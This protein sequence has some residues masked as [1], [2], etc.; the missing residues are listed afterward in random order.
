VRIPRSLKIGA[1]TFKVEVA[2]AEQM[3]GP[4]SKELQTNS[5][6]G[7]HFTFY[8][9]MDPGQLHIRLN[10]Q[11]VESMRVETLM[12]EVLHAIVELAGV[13]GLFKPGREEE[14]VQPLAHQLTQVLC[15]NAAFRRLFGR[16]K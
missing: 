1:H 14:I 8:G 16:R 11:V 10:G 2:T 6:A 15:D 7:R 5:E 12:H 3:G 13:R 9:D 4:N